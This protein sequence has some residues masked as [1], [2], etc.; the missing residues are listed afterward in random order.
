[1][2]KLLRAHFYRLRRSRALWL[3]MAAAFALSALF[4]LR[5]GAD[6]E[7]MNTLDVIFLQVFP[8][9]P[10]LHAAFISLFLGVEYQDGT[11]R[12]KLI[13]GH[14]R[15]TVYAA[16]LLVSIAGCFAI[17]LAWMASAVIGVVKFGW[18]AAPAEV[19][20]LNAVTILLLTAAL[21]AFLTL[22][23]LLIP[24]RAVSAVAAIL[25][26]FGLIVVGRVFYNA[27]CEPEMAS[28][29]VMTANGFEVGEPE[30]NP[31]YVSGALRTVYQFIVDA[32]PTGQAILLV[33]QELAHPAVS[34]CASVGIVLLSG[35]VGMAIFKRKDLK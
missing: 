25:L 16:Y 15:G 34:L 31:N 30:P 9:L 8:F 5:I 23:C 7:S 12:N 27:L 19:L 35:A 26:M 21:A 24:N 11:L 10:I 29:A 18:F 17:L 20:L 3:C 28:A 14:S 1:M 6:N 32:L 33:N 22:L 2:C 4:Q 13:A